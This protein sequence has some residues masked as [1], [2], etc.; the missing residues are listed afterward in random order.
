M[1]RRQTEQ[2]LP[3][4]STSPAT[5]STKSRRRSATPPARADGAHTAAAEHPFESDFYAPGPIYG[6]PPNRSF[7]SP[8]VWETPKQTII[9]PPSLIHCRPRPAPESLYS[10]VLATVDLGKSELLLRTPRPCSGESEKNQS[11]CVVGQ[12]RR[13]LMFSSRSPEFRKQTEIYRPRTPETQ[14]A[15]ETGSGTAD[16][17]QQRADGPCCPGLT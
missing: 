3:A 8:K 5:G 16:F 7:V 1:L 2:Q 11:G 12:V 10:L 15:S 13:H 14:Q 6:G 9:F 17:S 4:G